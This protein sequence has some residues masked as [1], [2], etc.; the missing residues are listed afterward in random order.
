MITSRS[1]NMSDETRRERMAAYRRLQSEYLV[2][3]QEL[4][5]KRRN[6]EAV[7]AEIRKLKLEI[8]RAESLLRDKASDEAK[9]SRDLGIMEAE[10]A[11]VKRRMNMMA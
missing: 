3:D 4:R 11:R 8:S 6:H 7:V 5:K 2:L 9:Q 1:G 10:C